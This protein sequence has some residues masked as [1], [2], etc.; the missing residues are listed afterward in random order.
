MCGS[1]WPGGAT[2]SC[3]ATARS[4][5]ANGSR[6]WRSPT[7]IWTSGRTCTATGSSP[8]SSVASI[9]DGIG[10]GTIADNDPLPT[11]AVNDV[12]VAEGDTGPTGTM[13]QQI[14]LRCWA[15]RSGQVVALHPQSHLEV[16][17]RRAY[18]TLSGLRGVWPTTE[19]RPPTADDIRCIDE[20]FGTLLLELPQRDSG[21]LLPTFADLTATVEE[22]RNRGAH[23]HFD[24]ARLWETTHHFGQDLA[25]IAA[26]ADSVYVSFYKTIGGISGAVLAGDADFVA[27]ARAWRHRYG[28]NVFQQWP[29]ALSALIGIE[30]ELPRLPSY[31]EHAARVADVLSKLPG[32]VVHPCPP[33]THQFQLWLPYPAEALNTACHRLAEEE[34]IWFAGRW[35]DQPPTPYAMTEITVASPSLAFSASDVASAAEAF[36]ARILVIHRGAAGGWWGCGV[37]GRVGRHVER[38]AAAP[39]GCRT[40]G[41]AALSPARGGWPGPGGCL[42][43]GQGD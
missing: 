33:H 17:E 21:F 11:L 38:P 28:G 41:L 25:T 19:P 10:L 12:T 31:V 30:A 5:C 22:A 29:S 26:L 15:D 4:L 9:T 18:A 40:M 43:L 39:P 13:A 24:G 20:P 3:P 42:R 32:S 16:H 2:A 7:S 35:T 1:G 37:S 6:R 23:V 8:S 14:A 27:S 34:K 36:L